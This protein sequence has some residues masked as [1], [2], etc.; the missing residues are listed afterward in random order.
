MGAFGCCAKLCGFLALMLALLI[1]WIS[2]YEHPLGVVFKTIFKLQGVGK[3]ATEQVPVDLVPMPRPVGEI[4]F[5]LPGGAKMPGNGLGMCCRPTAYDTV[6]VRRT[7][8]WYLL[9]GGR[10]IDTAALYLN[11]EAVGLGIR[12]AM[13]RGV[14][15]EEIFLTTK[16][17]PD[18]FGYQEAIDKS[19]RMLQELGVDYIDLVLLHAPIKLSP[20]L[21]FTF[22]KNKL[23]GDGANVKL[24][25]DREQ[26]KLRVDTWRGLSTLT[27]KGLIR[28]I[29]VSNFNIGHMKEI[30]ALKL[31]P[32]AANQMQFHPWVPD[33][34]KEIVGFCHEQNIVVTGYF[35]LGGFDHKDKALD[36]EVLNKIAKS[37]GRRPAQ[38]LLRWSLQ[39][40][41]AIIPGTGNP[42]HMTDNLGTYGFSLSEGDMK[43]LDDMSSLPISK[44]FIFFDF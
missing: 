33:W 29:G 3:P 44:D 38:I 27:E 13:E 22:F 21:L 26:S 14:P 41:V 31:A 36:L 25:D 12:D 32:I 35:S 19:T 9:Q 2:T 34:M 8:L 24:G 40:N 7:V 4:F 30:Q 39:K 5:D 1:G 16:I 43:R 23:F 18:N 15:R 6:S 20:K 10:H 28:N 17:F 37:H 11:H 42:K